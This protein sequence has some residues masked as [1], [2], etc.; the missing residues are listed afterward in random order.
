MIK[1]LIVAVIFSSLCVL[2]INLMADQFSF[3]LGLSTQSGQPNFES[4]RFPILV[5]FETITLWRFSFTDTVF[6]HNDESSTR[7]K[8]Q[9][10]GAERM[11]VHEIDE[12]FTLIGAF[13]PAYYSVNT[14]NPSGS[15]TAIGVMATGTLRFAFS[16][17][18]F[19]DGA[20]HYRNVAVKIDNG[21]VNGGYQGFVIGGGYFF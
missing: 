4:D 7:I 16:D 10:I 13:G 1:K 15:G 9:I 5:A 2:P 11:W 14:E 12:G 20:L 3:G 21:S 8:A 18:L 19:F 17:K 6:K